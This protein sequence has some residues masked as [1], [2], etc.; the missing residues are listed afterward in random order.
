MGEILGEKDAGMR[1]GELVLDQVGEKIRASRLG[2]GSLALVGL[3]CLR[4]YGELNDSFSW[5]AD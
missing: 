3:R 5:K 1:S 2:V 4:G